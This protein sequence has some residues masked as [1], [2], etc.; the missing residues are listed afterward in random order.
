[1][2]KYFVV[3]YAEDNGELPTNHIIEYS[4]EVT[5]K[6]DIKNVE[7]IIQNEY[8]GDDR[9]IRLINFKKLNS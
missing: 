6:Q 2:V 8:F 5:N 9:D 4:K 1:M 7:R 3:F